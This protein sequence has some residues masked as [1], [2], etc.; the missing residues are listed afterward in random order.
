[1]RIEVAGTSHVGMKR[2]HNED[3][4]LLLPEQNLFCVADGMGGHSAGEVA[5]QIAVEELAEFFRMTAKDEEVTWPYK[6][7]KQRTYQENRLATGIK[8]ANRRIFERQSSDAKYRGMGTTIVSIHFAP[9]GVLVAHVGDSRLYLLRKGEL[10]Q[11]TED[12]SLVNDY[13]KQ[14]QLTQEELDSFREKYKNV[15]I[16]ALGM[17]DTVQVDLGR[18]DPQDGDVFLLCSDGLPTM[19]PD[20]EIQSALR[21]GQDLDTSCQKLIEMA[22]AAGG[23]DNVTCIL[24]RYVAN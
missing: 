24:T 1:M 16:R 19:V 20:P 22:N 8:L 10:R 7:D 5:S 9:D 17:K 14:R 4:Y 6:M 23:A 2:N 15:I 13:M 21:G 3:S 18:V 11:I 12:H